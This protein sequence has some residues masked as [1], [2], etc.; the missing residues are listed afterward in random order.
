MTFL[1][2]MRL[3]SPLVA[4]IGLLSII[5]AAQAQDYTESHLKA[6]REAMTA[7][8]ASDQFD[9]ILP[10]LAKELQGQLTAKNPNLEELIATTVQEKALELV[11]RRT[12]LEDEIARVFAKIFTEEELT[13]ITAFY[14]TEA[15]KKMNRE[16]PIVTREMGKAAEIW[17][18]GLARDLAENVGKA[19]QAEVEK[20]KP[21]AATDGKTE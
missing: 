17:Q 6:A 5:T 8:N 18:R 14:N 9:T 12:A 15:G 7:L 20:E 1:S 4:V 2:R 21:A 11:G 10:S 19:I 13:A 3:L 16:L